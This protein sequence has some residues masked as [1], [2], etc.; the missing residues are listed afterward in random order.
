MRRL[1]ESIEINKLLNLNIYT[2]M[3]KQIFTSLKTAGLAM[4]CWLLPTFGWATVEVYGVNYDLDEETQTAVVV[5]TEDKAVTVAFIPENITVDGKTYEVT[6]IADCAFIDCHELS[7]AIIKSPTLTH[8][9]YSAFERCYALENLLLPEGLTSFNWEAFKDCRSLVSVTLP[10]TLKTIGDRSFLGCSSLNWIN[11]PANVHYLG[12]KWVS[13]C[14]L[15]ILDNKRE[16]PLSIKAGAFTGLDKEACVLVV[17]VGTKSAYQKAKVWKTFPNISEFVETGVCGENLI[18]TISADM[19]MTIS[20]TG[21]MYNYSRN[22]SASELTKQPVK[23]LIVEEGVTSIGSYAFNT[24]E[25]LSSIT[26]PNTVTTIGAFAFNETQWYSDQPEGVVYAG[27]VCYS[28]KGKSME[29]ADVV[30][31]D[32]TLGIASTAFF[33]CP[34][35]SLTIPSSVVSILPFFEYNDFYINL[36]ETAYRFIGS[37]T[38]DP[39]NPVYDSRENCNAIIETA[40]NKLIAGS[41]AMTIPN[42]VTEIG[43]FALCDQYDVVIPAT[44]T[45]V[46]NLAFGPDLSYWSDDVKGDEI[47]GTASPVESI[48]MEGSVPPAVTLDE[49][50]AYSSF[51]ADY[52]ITHFSVV[53]TEKCVLYVP[54]GSMSDYMNADGW[55]DF[56]HIVEYDPN[57]GPTAIESVRESSAASRQIFD[58]QGRRLNNASSHSIIIENGKK[59]IQR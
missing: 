41:E 20:G 56:L 55:K 47:F 52:D 26:L 1:C 34:V 22:P 3:K 39:A 29:D 54:L 16:T 12:D 18:Y 27:K 48:V 4:A 28:L 24:M 45:T 51:L 14:P 21:D 15:S 50:I 44:V 53:D 8:I 23:T 33:A 37:I 58:L 31:E 35:N 43:P 6:A 2:I 19:T 59:R 32:G 49:Q 5:G 30:L 36:Y 25:T 10:T 11:I 9:G 38:V 42:G 7:V 40:T 46:D 13:G 17:P 57:D